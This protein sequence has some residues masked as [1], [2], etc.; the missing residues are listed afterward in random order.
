MSE[1]ISLPPS[2][3][4]VVVDLPLA[5]QQKVRDDGGPDEGRDVEELVGECAGGGEV[6]ITGIQ[7][8][9][10]H[11]LL[12]TNHE[13]GTNEPTRQCRKVKHNT[14]ARHDQLPT[15][16]TKHIQSYCCSVHTCI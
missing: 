7:A 16:N 15:H 14:P 5:H 4:V 3:H 8:P 10:A 9:G 12:D 2:L 11:P 13:L 6:A 1:C